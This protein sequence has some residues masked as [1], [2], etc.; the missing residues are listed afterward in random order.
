MLSL[1]DYIMAGRGRWG[2]FG[3]W[4]GGLGGGNSERN[5]DGSHDGQGVDG[6][7]NAR[8]PQ[9]EDRDGQAKARGHGDNNVPIQAGDR[10]RGQA[11]RAGHDGGDV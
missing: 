5:R 6:S 9:D 2:R 8:Q 10:G 3:R 7:G 11:E 1:D 4:R